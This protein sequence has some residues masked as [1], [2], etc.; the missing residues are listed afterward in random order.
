MAKCE[1]I[2]AIF[3]FRK[4]DS[5]NVSAIALYNGR[6]AFCALFPGLIVVR[7]DE[8]LIHTIEIVAMINGEAASAT[9]AGPCRHASMMMNGNCIGHAFT[10]NQSLGFI[11]THLED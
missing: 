4:I 5:K 7:D 9:C 2:T 3:A 10:P 8:N 1:E 6:C 11:R